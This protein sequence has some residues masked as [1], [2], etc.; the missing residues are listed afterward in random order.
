M[1]LKNVVP[2]GRSFQEYREIFN[3]TEADLDKSILGCGDGPAS[4]NSE[5]TLRGGRV[6]SI[7][8]TYLFSADAL[9]SRIAEVYQEIMPQAEKNKEMYI[10]E[11]IPSVE[12]LGK[13]RMN[14][15]NKFIADYETGKSEGRYIPESLPN[16]SFND[17]S[18]D[19]ALCS[20]YLFLYSE[21]VDLEQ[22]IAS[23]EELSRVSREVR[24][25]PLLSL[26]GEESPH[27]KEV[28]L[29]LSTTELSCSIENVGYQFQKGATQMLV[30]KSV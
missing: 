2:W 3:L 19:L 26:N 18:F 29:A 14:A 17:K 21:H 11:N 22:H 16:L 25:Y 6:T 28:I 12:A 1:E 30:V 7:D 9:Q 13:I 10:W 4:F 15:M 24:I 20:H 23:I 5:L 8:P 27:L